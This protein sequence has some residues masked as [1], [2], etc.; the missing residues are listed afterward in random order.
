MK[1]SHIHLLGVV[2]FD[3]LGDTRLKKALEYEK[4]DAITIGV[5]EWL[6]EYFDEEWLSD[7]WDKLNYY[8]GITPN[9]K[10]FI[11]D[12]ICN[13]YRFPVTV[14]RDYAES[15]DVPIHYIGDPVDLEEVR[16]SIK[17]PNRSSSEAINRSETMEEKMKHAENKYSTFQEWFSNPDFASQIMMNDFVQRFLSDDPQREAVTADNLIKLAYRVSGKIVHVAEAELLTDDKRG[18][19][20]YERVR[21]LE[22]TRG[23]IADYQ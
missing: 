17:G 15:R 12:Q 10:S 3:P 9:V 23:T 22:P 8:V 18:Q 21:Q 11:E 14:S 7:Q 2:G 20:L 13:I 5:S 1:P 19:S 4:P 16:K 6:V